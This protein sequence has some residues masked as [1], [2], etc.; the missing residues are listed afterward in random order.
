MQ[1]YS[2][3]SFNYI[4][5]YSFFGIFR[6]SVIMQINICIPKLNLKTSTNIRFHLC[7]KKNQLHTLEGKAV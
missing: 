3:K 1:S 2:E 5:V 7:I 4:Y 6:Y